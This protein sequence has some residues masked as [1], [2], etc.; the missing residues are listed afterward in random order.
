MIELDFTVPP[1]LE[2]GSTGLGVGYILQV[3]VTASPEIFPDHDNFVS[4]KLLDGKTVLAEKSRVHRS[5]LAV[6]RWLDE[7][8]RKAA[9]ILERQAVRRRKVLGR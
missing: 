9:Q 6:D 3:L 7:N 5:E 8:G 2:V 1:Q 4:V